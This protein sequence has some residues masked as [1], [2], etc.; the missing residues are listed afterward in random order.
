MK[1]TVEGIAG[2]EGT[3]STTTDAT[4]H[5][6]LPSV[7][8]NPYGASLVIASL[9]GYPDSLWTLPQSSGTEPIRKEFVLRPGLVLSDQLD[10]QLTENDPDY[11]YDGDEVF[12]LPGK[13]GPV[14][15]VFL[16]PQTDLPLQV[17]ATWPGADPLGMW[18]EKRYLEVSIEAT[19][20]SAGNVLE[21][22]LP[23]GWA[24]DRLNNAILTVGMR[25]PRGV[26]SGPTPIHLSLTPA[27]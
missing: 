2:P 23:S 6:D 27:K 15:V 5:Y 22:L 18:V 16:Q 25:G 24:N 1:V 12:N 19:R 4:G 3:A 8:A 10:V 26:L 14:K 13:R 17:T 11:G 7:R 9:D 21:L 20:S